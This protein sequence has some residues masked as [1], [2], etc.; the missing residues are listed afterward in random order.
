MKKNSEEERSILFWD[1][2]KKIDLGSKRPSE[3]Y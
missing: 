1:D 2:Y 3:F